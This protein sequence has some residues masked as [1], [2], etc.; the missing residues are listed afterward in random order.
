MASDL[1]HEYPIKNSLDHVYKLLKGPDAVI[2]RTCTALSLPVRLHLLYP[3]HGMFSAWTMLD[4]VPH[5]GDNVFYAEGQTELLQQNYGAVVV[6]SK[7]KYV[8]VE[9]EVT[10]VVDKTQTKLN[11]KYVAHGNEPQMSCAYGNVYLVVRVGKFGERTVVVDPLE[12]KR[13]KRE[14]KK[15]ARAEAMARERERRRLLAE[16][17]ALEDKT[18]EM[19]REDE[20]SDRVESCGR[21]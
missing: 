11:S 2:L 14:E 21:S 13:K 8:E 5:F 19:S 15:R 6:A 20:R 10:W 16:T 3:D 1:Q 4:Y 12:E 9:D 17:K 7:S 18:R